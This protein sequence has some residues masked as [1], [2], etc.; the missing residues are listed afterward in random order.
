MIPIQPHRLIEACG[1]LPLLHVPTGEVHV[2]C[3]GPL[4]EAFAA[5][6][7]LW[8]DVKVIYTPEPTPRVRDRR[9]TQEKPAPGSCQAVLLSPEQDIAQGGSLLAKGGILSASTQDG[10]RW[11]PLID[12]AKK[13]LGNAMPWRENTP[14]PIYGILAVAGTFKPSRMREPPP[15]AKRLHSKYL[16]CLFTFGKDELPLVLPKMTNSDKVSTP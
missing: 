13:Q 14:M 6:A 7:C 8:P 12:S 11:R 10:D 2:A 9:I 15:Q 3:L 5:I 1:M 4:A 16:P